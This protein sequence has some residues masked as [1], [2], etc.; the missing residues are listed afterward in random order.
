MSDPIFSYDQSIEIGASPAKVYALVSDMARYGEW[1]PLSMGGKWL[2]SGTGKVGDWF[3]GHNRMGKMEYDAKVEIT[4]ADEGKDFGFWTMGQAA[5]IVHWRYSMQASAAGTTLT[6][7]Y[8][9][10][11]APPA[12]AKGGDAVVKGWTDSVSG[13]ITQMLEGIKSAAEA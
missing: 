1:S 4:E 8:R 11:T 2:D 7:H 6:E 13:N 3:E 12:M 10:Y 9:M 5:N